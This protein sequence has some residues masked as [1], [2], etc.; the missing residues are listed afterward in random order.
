MVEEQAQSIRRTRQT[1]K[2]QCEYYI[3]VDDTVDE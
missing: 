1:Q 3:I 2:D